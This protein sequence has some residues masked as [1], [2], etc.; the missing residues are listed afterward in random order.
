MDGKQP[1]S[2]ACP[3]TCPRLPD[4]ARI[5]LTHRFVEANPVGRPVRS[6][7]GSTVTPLVGLPD[8]RGWDNF[9]R[10]VPLGEVPLDGRMVGEEGRHAT[11]V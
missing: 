6:S 1:E 4:E 7:P 9:V 10:L 2:E 3:A 5:G 11:G 8:L